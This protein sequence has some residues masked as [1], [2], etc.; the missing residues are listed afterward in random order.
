MTSWAR[1]SQLRWWHQLFAHK[2]DIAQQKRTI[3]TKK[4]RSEWSF[5]FYFTLSSILLNNQPSCCSSSNRY[6]STSFSRYVVS[7]SIAFRC[8]KYV[9]CCASTFTS[10][11]EQAIRSNWICSSSLLQIALHFA[12]RCLYVSWILTICFNSVFFGFISFVFFCFFF[13]FCSESTDS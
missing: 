8:V 9:L 5:Q 6:S 2:N 11:F 12:F 13:W 7:V 4:Q 3:A 10:P 1:S